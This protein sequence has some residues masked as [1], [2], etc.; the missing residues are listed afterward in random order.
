M[1]DAKGYSPETQ[2][3]YPILQFI[4]EDEVLTKMVYEMAMKNGFARSLDKEGISLFKGALDEMQK[5]YMGK[6]YEKYNIFIGGSDKVA[7]SIFWEDSETGEKAYVGGYETEKDAAEALNGLPDLGPGKD[8]F[9][10][11]YDPHHIF[12]VVKPDGHFNTDAAHLSLNNA[13]GELYNAVTPPA[14]AKWENYCKE[15]DLCGWE[16]GKFIGY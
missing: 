2:R 10:V 1:L 15:H 4:H 12:K 8:Y 7:S 16:K 6:T 13:I 14:F 3:I 11:N 5:I 9:T